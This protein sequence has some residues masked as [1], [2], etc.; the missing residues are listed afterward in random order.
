[1]IKKNFTN[2]KELLFLEPIKP[3]MTVDEIFNRLMKVFKEKGI[4]VYPDKTPHKGA[5]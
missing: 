2:K 4:K 3:E 1:M 5:E